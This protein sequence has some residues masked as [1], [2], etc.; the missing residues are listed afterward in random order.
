MNLSLHLLYRITVVVLLCF[1]TSSAYMLYH[2]N[3]QAWQASLATA[4]SLGGQLDSQLVRIHAGSFATKQFPDFGLWQKTSNVSGLCVHYVSVDGATSRRLCNGTNLPA[5]NWPDGFGKLYRSLLKSDLQL[6]RPIS[7]KGRTYGFLTITPNDNT[8]IGQA[9]ETLCHLLGVSVLTIIA[10]GLLVYFSINRALQPAQLIV[11]GL[12]H[13]AKGDLAYRLPTFELPEWQHTA[14]AINQLAA[15][16]QRLLAE[17]QILAVRLIAV[18]EEERRHLARELHDELGQCLADISTIAASISF[19]EEAQQISHISQ[20]KMG[21]IREL[22]GRLRPADLDELGLAASLKNLVADW[23]SRS[24]NYAQYQIKLEGDCSTLPEPIIVTL[25]RAAQEC[26]GN[27][28]KH[29]AAG[30]VKLSLVVNAT[31]AILTVEDDGIATEL[32]FADNSGIGLLG[33]R[34]RVNSL[35]GH[36]TLAIAQ[37]HGLVVTAWLPR[38]PMARVQRHGL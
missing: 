26:L 19:V 16:Q 20:Q 24:V 9:W 14:E 38:Y 15:C 35:Q 25:F 11:A 33:I 12:A 1:L 8:E 27:I 17:R 4:D 29:S 32:P 36:L 23:Q 6:S 13:M 7:F 18:Q 37:P 34:E 10:V 2:G 21:N 5:L 28:A 22:L 3:R 31:A 30:N